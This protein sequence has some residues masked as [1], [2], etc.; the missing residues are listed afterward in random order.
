M[1]Q[2][3]MFSKWYSRHMVFHKDDFQCLVDFRFSIKNLI[4]TV[5]GDNICY[6]QTKDIIIHPL[7]EYLSNDISQCG[8]TSCHT[9]NIFINDQSFKSNLTGKKKRPLVMIDFHVAPQM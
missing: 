4:L 6:V 1:S 3:Q 9:C 8:A 7:T 5:E 2:L